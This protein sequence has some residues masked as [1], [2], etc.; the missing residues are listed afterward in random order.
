VPSYASDVGP[1]IRA[2]CGTCHAPGGIEQNRPYVDY[3]VLVMDR[4]RVLTQVYQCAMPPA[5]APQLSSDERHALL[6]WIVCKTPD[7]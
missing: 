1:I 3:D 7:N 4:V 6:Q 2:R 5:C